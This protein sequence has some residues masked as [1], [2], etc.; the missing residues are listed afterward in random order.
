MFLS[1]PAVFGGVGGGRAL[2]EKEPT[3]NSGRSNATVRI[4][5]KYRSAGVTFGYDIF[6]DLTR[7]QEGL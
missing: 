1:N 6:I 2:S 4:H 3:G 7:E 5:E